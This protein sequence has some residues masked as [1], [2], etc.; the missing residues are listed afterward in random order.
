MA[1]RRVAHRPSKR[2]GQNFLVDQRVAEQIVSNVSPGPN[3]SILEPGPGHGTLTQLLQEKA[4]KVI[5]IEKDPV[6]VRDLKQK[7]ADSQTVIV[8]EGDFLE[9]A[10]SLPS[11]NKIVSTPPYYLSSKMV[12]WLAGTKF[13]LASI[14][15]Q[16]EF[17]DR[18]L[19]SPG[20]AD[21]GRLTVAAQRKLNVGRVQ[22]IPRTAFNPRP[23]VD[24]ILLRITPTS[25]RTE[26]DEPLFEEL[27][28]GLFNQRRRLVK[29][30]L[31]H[32]LALK[33][34]AEIG[35]K[36]L[37]RVS[38]PDARVYQLS[39]DQFENLS[40]QLW[41]IVSDTITSGQLSA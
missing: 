9:M 26:L 36:V 4:G 19:A 18:L 24:S 8:L 3:D 31:R 29:S 30:S 21:Y 6:L 41:R 40:L 14:V 35:K 10:G 16:K 23:K 17:G 34:D 38:V 27:V 15:F 7:F 25:A 20:T 39:I 13:D 11:F 1:S 28:R 33:F 5:A 12:L 2:L 22:V 37:E 32:F